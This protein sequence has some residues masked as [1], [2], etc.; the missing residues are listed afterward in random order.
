M[1]PY[2]CRKRRT[3]SAAGTPLQSRASASRMS[4]S[5]IVGAGVA[6]IVDPQSFFLADDRRRLL[7]L[8]GARRSTAVGNRR[9]A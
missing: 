6:I 8:A 5:R 7:R 4:K 9:T 1:L 2:L 3:V